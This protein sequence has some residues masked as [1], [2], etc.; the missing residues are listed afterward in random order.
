MSTHSSTGGGTLGRQQIIPP[1]ISSHPTTPTIKTS[2]FFGSNLVM[3]DNRHLPPTNKSKMNFT[4]FIMVF[5][6]PD[7]GVGHDQQPHLVQTVPGRKLAE[8]LEPYLSLHGFAPDSVE[9]FLEKS[10]SPIPESSDS[11]YLAGHK[12][13]VRCKF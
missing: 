11:R 13:Y 5:L 9:Y 10:S 7:N 1:N 2:N 12:I 8:C 4:D 6:H 3:S